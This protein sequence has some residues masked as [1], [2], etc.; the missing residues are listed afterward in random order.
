MI[1]PATPADAAAI[2]EIYNYYILNSIITFEEESLSIEQ[3][4]ERIAEIQDPYPWL[5]YEDNGSIMGY[6]YAGKWKSRCSYRHSVECRI[7]SDGDHSISSVG[8]HLIS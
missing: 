2:A 4:K 8:D 1:R 5:V 7:S 6:A 3:M